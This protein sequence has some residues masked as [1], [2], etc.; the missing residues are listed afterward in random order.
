MGIGVCEPYRSWSR[1]AARDPNPNPNHVQSQSKLEALGALSAIFIAPAP[2]TAT[3]PAAQGEMGE[4]MSYYYSQVINEEP[5]YWWSSNINNKY[6]I[7]WYIVWYIVFQ[8]LKTFRKYIIPTNM[9]LLFL[10]KNIL[11]TF[12]D[13]FKV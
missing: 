9:L 4:V 12:S 6:C 11:R 7:V 3:S 2:A 10:I 13:L 5:L 8:H 1:A